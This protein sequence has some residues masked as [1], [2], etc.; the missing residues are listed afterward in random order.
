MMPNRPEQHEIADQ[1]VAGV[2]RVLADAGWACEVVRSDYG[3]DLICQ[4]SY[5]GTVDPH[6]IL[7]QVKSTKRRI[8]NSGLKIKIKKNTL[9]KWLL[10]ANLVV[11]CFWSVP[12]E[13]SVRSV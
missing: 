13:I 7:V 11:V 5:R 8:T 10:D 9:L 4:T 12:D 2:A 3:E 6:R 1:G